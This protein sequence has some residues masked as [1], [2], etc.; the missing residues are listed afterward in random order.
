MRP[1][2]GFWKRWARAILAPALLATIFAVPLAA[3]VQCVQ[4]L[5]DSADPGS[6]SLRACIMAAIAANNGETINFKSSLNGGTIT[7]G[8]AL[9]AITGS[10]TIA[11]PGANLLTI[12]GSNLYQ[13]FSIAFGPTV[14]ISGLTIANGSSTTGGA[15]F[16]GG[17]LI[18]NNS[19]FSGNTASS[20]GGGIYNVGTLM[21]TSSTFSGNTA[22]STAGGIYNGGVGR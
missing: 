2:H 10:M 21:V 20:T 18:V 3:S 17:T 7:L 4:N 11:G 19:T 1:L 13:I 16:N 22:G 9:P 8:S 5:G 12:S 6:G 14:T 15:I